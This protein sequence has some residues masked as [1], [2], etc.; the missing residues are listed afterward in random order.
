MLRFYTNIYQKCAPDTH[1]LNKNQ[2]HFLMHKLAYVYL[3]I[4]IYWYIC[5]HIFTLF[6][7]CIYK[8]V[9]Q[10]HDILIHQFNF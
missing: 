5:I 7:V 4:H 1:K 9:S 10:F 8:N 3:F 6:Y 2:F